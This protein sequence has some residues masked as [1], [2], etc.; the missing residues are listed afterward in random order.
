MERFLAFLLSQDLV[1]FRELGRAFGRGVHSGLRPQHQENEWETLCCD[2][3]GLR[4]PGPPVTK[5]VIC[6]TEGSEQQGH[7][8]TG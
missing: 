2:E 6:L 7:L 3:R 4:P 1:S 8:A 5:E